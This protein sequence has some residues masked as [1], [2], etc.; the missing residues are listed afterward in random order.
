MNPFKRKQPWCSRGVGPTGKKLCYCGCGK[1]VTAPLRTSHSPRCFKEWEQRN[2]P[3]VIRRI[4]KERDKEICALCGLDT[5]IEAIKSRDY[6]PLLRW[7][8][9]K[10]TVELIQQ[11][12]L[13][14]WEGKV[15]QHEAHAYSHIEKVVRE[16]LKARGWYNDHWWEADHIIP[17]A[18]GGGGCGPEGYRTLCI[19]CHRKQTAALAKRLAAKRREKQLIS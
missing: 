6:L 1:E 2:V 11:G 19:A 17:V 15:I 3:A 14:D 8:A 13:L 7:F 12:K 9:K 16:E 10:E 18:E 4:L 5:R